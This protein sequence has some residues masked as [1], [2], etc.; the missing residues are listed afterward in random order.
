MA[1][2]AINLINSTENFSSLALSV[3]GNYCAN[4][5]LLF[6]R[7]VSSR[8]MET[9]FV[10]KGV[11]RGAFWDSFPCELRE[12]SLGV[13]S[14]WNNICFFAALPDAMRENV[15]VGELWCLIK[16]TSNRNVHIFAQKV[17]AWVEDKVCHVLEDALTRNWYLNT[18][19]IYTQ[20]KLTVIMEN[21]TTSCAHVH[22]PAIAEKRLNNKFW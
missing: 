10:G 15:V 12:R 3:E 14:L 16:V 21:C 6:F 2:V 17:F 19:I 9:R 4:I 22:P 1:R 20:C 18:I 13:S 8:S 5:I 7:F 11:T